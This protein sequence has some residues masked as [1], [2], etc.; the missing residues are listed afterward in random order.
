VRM[1][2]LREEH[3]ASVFFLNMTFGLVLWGALM[4]A[5]PSIGAMYDDPRVS[6][7]LRVAAM[8]FLVNFFGAV[9][10]ALLQ[11]DM[12]FKEMAYV[13][14]TQ[15]L[16]FFPVAVGMAWNGYGYWALLVGQLVSNA[17]STAAKVYFGRW[18]PSL[19]FTRQGLADTVP[20]GMGIYAK[21]LLTYTAENLDSL[22]VGSLFGVT[23]LGY[24]DK[25]FNAVDNL[26][27]RLA[28][29][30][31][32]MFRIFALIQD[33]RERFIRAYNKVVLAGTIVTLPVFAGLIVAAPEFIVVVFGE[34][35]RPAVVP[36]QF[37]CGAGALRLVSG[38]ASSAVQA[39]GQI[40]GE[41]WRKV[42]HVALIVVL[43]LAFKPWGI[44]GAGVA[45][46]LATL[47]LGVLM[48]GLVGSIVGFTWRERLVPLRPSIIG[49]IGTAAIVSAV[50][51]G[52]RGA[53]PAVPDWAVLVVQTTAGG[54]FWLAFIL[55]VRF[56]DLQDVVDEVIDDVLPPFIRGV[57]KRVRP[58]N[59]PPEVAV[60]TSAREDVE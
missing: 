6:G 9:E 58:G 44:A 49:A 5:A 42:A 15:P 60:A 37:L 50:T 27:N 48:Q 3:R 18:R 52:V 28:L 36:F 11:R 21:R 33:E 38:Y 30:G 13:E 12:K 55:F 20:F 16:V 43:L 39:N 56:S 40:W 19:A 2:D 22:I 47:V 10:F 24:Y 26:T 7:A 1:K 45:V 59:R 14:W 17:A 41:V 23:W 53:V 31:N 32:V 46:F 25:A 57:V 4:F 51:I 35:W 54:L 29:G 8:I 34:K